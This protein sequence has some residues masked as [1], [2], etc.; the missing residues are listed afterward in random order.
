MTVGILSLF[1][2]YYAIKLLIGID[3]DIF[4]NDNIYA[5]TLT[6][7]CGAAVCISALTA[8]YFM[9]EKN[10]KCPFCESKN[11]YLGRIP[12]PMDT[13]GCVNCE[14]K[15]ELMKKANMSKEDIL[16]ILNNG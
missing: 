8:T 16:Y 15:V 3:H 14:K 10:I 11:L 6:L 13:Y 2:T 1:I 5:I 4:L 9:R 7:C 12:L